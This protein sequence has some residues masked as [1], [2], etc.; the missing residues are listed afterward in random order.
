MNESTGKSG[1]V[2][3]DLGRKKRKAVK[4]LRKGQGKL[5]DDVRDAIDELSS[6]GTVKEGA[7]PVIIIVE[8]R[9]KEGWSSWM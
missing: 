8:R 3:I 1:P 2:I 9:P 5:M 6:A 7:Q 4:L